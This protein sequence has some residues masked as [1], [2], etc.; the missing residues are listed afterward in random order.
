MP[1][2]MVHFKADPSSWPSD[3][4]EILTMWEGVVAGANQLLEQ[5]LFEGNYWVGPHE[6]YA[7]IDAE[8]KAAVIRMTTPFFPLFTQ[9]IMELT[10]HPEAGEALLAGAKMAADSA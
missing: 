6:G 9:H 8:S 5:G 7:L 10:P 1:K 3:P 4:S 2:Y